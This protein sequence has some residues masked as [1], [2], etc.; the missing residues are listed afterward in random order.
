M[1]DRA[2]AYGDVRPEGLV[3]RQRAVVDHAGRIAEMDGAAENEVAEEAAVAVAA[4][5][6]ATRGTKYRLAPGT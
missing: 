3:L 2:I 4:K 5:G 1:L 6:P